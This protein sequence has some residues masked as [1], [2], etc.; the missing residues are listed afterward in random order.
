MRW[1]LWVRSLRGIAGEVFWD[2]RYGH[3]EAG[4]ETRPA[5]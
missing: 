5:K 3:D 2:F 1:M 4:N